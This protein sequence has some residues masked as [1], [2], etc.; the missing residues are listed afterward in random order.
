LNNDKIAGFKAGM[1]SEAGQQK[2]GLHAPTA[3]VLFSSGKKVNNAAI[4]LA[5]SKN[6]KIETEIGFVIGKTIDKAV[7]SVAGLQESIQAVMPVIELP[8]LGFAD[9]QALKGV[10]IIAANVAAAQFIVG[11]EREVK[12]QD[13]NAVSVTL[14]LN[15]EEIN[16][17]KGTDA[18]GDQWQAALWLVN[19]MLEQGWTMEPGHIFITGALGQMLPGNPGKYI[20]D[21]GNFGKIC[22]EMKSTTRDGSQ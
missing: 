6:L 7:E 5:M 19:I 21:Y 2:F 20:A 11:Q 9:M 22:F 15:D 3:G 16:S 18:F 14:T 1:T 13:L 4:N 8:D 10:D 17:G 12:D